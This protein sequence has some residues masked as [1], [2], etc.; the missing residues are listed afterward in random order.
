[1]RGNPHEIV[2]TR[3]RVIMV[4]QNCVKLKEEYDE[5]KER[6][7]IH[8]QLCCLTPACLSQQRASVRYVIADAKVL[9]YMFINIQ[10]KPRIIHKKLQLRYLMKR[11]G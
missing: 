2:P 1:M 9:R 10:L 5:G 3:D 6:A 4:V 7:G 11:F 8:M